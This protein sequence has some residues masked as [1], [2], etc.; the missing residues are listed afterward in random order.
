VSAEEI[1]TRGDV[2]PRGSTGF[3]VEQA[4]PLGGK[5][6]RGR[7]VFERAADEAVARADL[8]RQRVLSSVRT[9]FYQ[10]LTVERRI[11]VHERLAALGRDA[12]GVT[13]QLFNVGAADRPDYLESEIEAR[14]V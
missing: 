8:Q 14:R 10:L 4:I 12:T 9:L 5:L 2:D 13:A 1:T 3:F 7:T 11:D 6:G